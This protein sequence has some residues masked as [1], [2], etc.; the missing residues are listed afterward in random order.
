MAM[1]GMAGMLGCPQMALS[2]SPSTLAG[3]GGGVGLVD[4]LG[5]PIGEPALAG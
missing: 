4:G 3:L 1:A 5:Q 2:V